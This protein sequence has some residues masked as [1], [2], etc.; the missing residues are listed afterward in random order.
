MLKGKNGIGKLVTW[1]LTDRRKR[2]KSAFLFFLK[3]NGF[4]LN[5]STYGQLTACTAVSSIFLSRLS[6]EVE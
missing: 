5:N 1:R 6:E 3:I 4:F 2:A